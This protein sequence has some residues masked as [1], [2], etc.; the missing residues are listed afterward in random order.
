[1]QCVCPTSASHG[2]RPARRRARSGWPFRSPCVAAPAPRVLR[3]DSRG[4]LRRLV[5]EDSGRMTGPISAVM[6]RG[7]RTISD[8]ALARDAVAAFREHRQDEIPVVD[9]GGRPVGLLDVQDLIS[10]RLVRD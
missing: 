5:L 3:G 9:E 1:M 2:K 8:S 7:P 4:H 6:T 10:R